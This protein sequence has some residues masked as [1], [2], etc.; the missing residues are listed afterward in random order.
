MLG[1]LEV[2]AGAVAGPWRFQ[3]A[4]P[5]CETLPERWRFLIGGCGGVTH[6]YDS[7][8]DPLVVVADGCTVTVRLTPAQ[9]PEL[10][11]ACCGTVYSY[12]LYGVLADQSLVAVGGEGRGSIVVRGAV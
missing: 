8:A 3:V 11:A 10:A 5:K 4:V 1:Q 6:T 2:Y 7:E 12:A 9:A